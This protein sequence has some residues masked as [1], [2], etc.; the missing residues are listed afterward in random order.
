M[1]MHHNISLFKRAPLGVA[2]ANGH[3]E[4]IRLLLDNGAD[5]DLEDQY[6]NYQQSNTLGCDDGTRRNSQAPH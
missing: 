3:N 6:E 1:D 2:A 4:V 5:P